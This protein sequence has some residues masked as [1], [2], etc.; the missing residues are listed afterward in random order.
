MTGPGYGVRGQGKETR[1]ENAAYSM[2]DSMD[3]GMDG[4]DCDC[5]GMQGMRGMGALNTQD[6]NMVMAATN[7]ALLQDIP[8]INRTDLAE[9]MYQMA[10]IA[11]TRW[12]AP[13]PT[14]AALI[15]LIRS[16]AQYRNLVNRIRTTGT[17]YADAGDRT[18]S[19]Y[20]V[21]GGGL[22]TTKSDLIG[23]GILAAFYIYGKKA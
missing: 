5:A 20:N 23:V 2:G 9:A 7:Q 6:A 17:V 11:Q 22:L 15:D 12:S 13:I 8:N 14:G 3:D 19:P 16:S 1:S 21:M 10:S 18:L 4:M